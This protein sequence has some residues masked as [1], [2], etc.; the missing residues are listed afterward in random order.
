MTKEVIR[1]NLDEK[2]I[3]TTLSHEGRINC[4]WQFRMF[5]KNW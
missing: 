3:E 2:T 1:T 4:W 5:S